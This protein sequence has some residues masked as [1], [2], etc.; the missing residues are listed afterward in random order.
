M[1]QDEVADFLESEKLS[2]EVD[3][4]IQGHSGSDYKVNVRVLIRN[5]EAL[6]ATVSPKTPASAIS[7]V[8]HVLRMWHDVNGNR[9]KYTLFNDEVTQVRSEDVYLLEQANSFVHKWSA[10]E[11]LVA[12]LKAEERV[13]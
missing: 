12:A 10:R 2:A 11:L 4:P 13:H 7:R 6:I 3:V 5:R 9:E 8:D 1:F